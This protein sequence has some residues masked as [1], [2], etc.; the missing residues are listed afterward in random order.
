MYEPGVF[1]Q[2][3]EHHNG[4]FFRVEAF[5]LIKLPKYD[6]FVKEFFDPLQETND[7]QIVVTRSEFK[8]AP[9]YAIMQCIK[10]YEGKPILELD[11]KFT[12]E[13]GQTATLDE[14]MF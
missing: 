13:T 5:R 3:F 10:C 8:C 9:A 6:F 4:T 11:R 14:P 2:L 12:V 1:R 7:Q